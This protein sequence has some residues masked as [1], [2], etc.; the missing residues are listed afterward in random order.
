MSVRFFGLIPRLPSLSIDEFHDHYR[1]PHGTLVLGNTGMSR[2]V[3]SHRFTTD[4]PGAD[5]ASG[6]PYEAVAEVTF[7]SLE[8]GLGLSTSENFVT[9]VLPDEPYFVEPTALAWLFTTNTKEAQRPPR[10]YAEEQW[11]PERAPVSVKLLQ[12][13]DEQDAAATEHEDEEARA[14]E[15]GALRFIRSA[16]A[17]GAHTDEAPAFAAVR[18]LWWPS[19]FDLESGAR[20]SPEAWQW[21]TTLNPGSV[22]L[23]A[24]AERFL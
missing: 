24:T 12:F 21:L 14:F 8:I 2:Y 6:D 11:S 1:H 3:Q 15:V 20:S 19:R 9:H 18:E 13:L 22:S 5:A 16:P 10:S 4:L 7:D 23:V 17:A